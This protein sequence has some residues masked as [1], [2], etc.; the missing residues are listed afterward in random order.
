MGLLRQMWGPPPAMQVAQVVSGVGMI[1]AKGQK[2]KSRTGPSL[3]VSVCL[4]NRQLASANCSCSLTKQVLRCLTNALADSLRGLVD[5]PNRVSYRPFAAGSDVVQ[6]AERELK[7]FRV[8]TFTRS[9]L[10]QS[11]VSRFPKKKTGYGERCRPSSA[12]F[13]RVG[14]GTRLRSFY[15]RRALR[16]E[17]LEDCESACAE[18]RDIQCRSFNFRYVVL[19]I[20][21][22]LLLG[23]AF[24]LSAARSVA[25]SGRYTTIRSSYL[26]RVSGTIPSISYLQ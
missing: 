4:G 13:R 20:L 23:L 16:A 19:L 6:R 25:Q 2:R 11:C 18:A 15:I 10:S 21:A 3:R 14:Y 12:A 1:D 7:A 22:R 8:D 26:R 9:V 5:V 17:R 24:S